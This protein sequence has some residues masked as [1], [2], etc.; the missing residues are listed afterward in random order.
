MS[1]L[2]DALLVAFSVEW[3]EFTLGNGLV[4]AMVEIVMRVFEES[5][6]V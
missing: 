5:S 6:H 2:L 3:S 4:D 1:L